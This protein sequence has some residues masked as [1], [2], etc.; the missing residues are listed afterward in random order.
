MKLAIISPYIS[1]TPDINS[2][3]SQ[4]IN[5]AVELA[6]SGVSVDIITLKRKPDDSEKEVIRPGVSIYRLPLLS[7]WLEKHL[8]QPFMRNL[9]A[10]LKK[11]QYYIIQSSEDFSLVTLIA[12]FYALLNKSRFVIYQGIYGYSS[13]RSIRLMMK[14]YDAFAGWLL[15]KVCWR[16]VCKTNASQQYML[17]KGYRDIRVIPIGVNTSLFYPDKRW[18]K[19]HFEILCVGKLIELK[20]YPLILETFYHLCK[21]N[22]RVRLTIIG[23]GPCK[24]QIL[25][26]IEEK[27]LAKRV[28]LIEKV[29]NNIIRRYYSKADLFLLFSKVEIFGMVILEAMACGCPVVATPIPGALDVIV[30]GENGLMIRDADPAVIAKRIDSVLRNNALLSSMKKKA[31]ETATEKYSWQHIARQYYQVYRS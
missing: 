4:Q 19:D 6:K 12:A 28:S 15:R 3:Q 26:L 13:K 27:R 10:L 7:R 11:K 2:Y 9:S 5:L 1:S 18:G 30:D 14:L 23:T 24:S 29:P 31:F 21:F 8:R 25:N 22:P 20:N 17:K 16:V